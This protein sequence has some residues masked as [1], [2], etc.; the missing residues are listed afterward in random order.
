MQTVTVPETG[1]TAYVPS[2]EHELVELLDSSAP[3]DRKAS[4]MLIKGLGKSVTEI[5][6][7]TVA[8][9]LTY[10]RRRLLEI[11]GKPL[12]DD[13]PT[14]ARQLKGKVRSDPAFW[15]ELEQS[16]AAEPSADEIIDDY[17]AGLMRPKS[18]K[19]DG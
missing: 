15:A 3:E 12:V 7:M 6:T 13:R 18:S 5:V 10:V 14:V 2:T 11:T 16:R 17:L 1:W 4:M 19:E 8:D 9:R